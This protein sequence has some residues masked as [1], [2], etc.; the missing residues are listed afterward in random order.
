MFHYETLYAVCTDRGYKSK[1][2]ISEDLSKI[3]GKEPST[4]SSQM[5]DGWNLSLDDAARI[6]MY[7]EM[8]PKEFC[9]TFLYGLFEETPSGSYRCKPLVRQKRKENPDE[10]RQRT[11]QEII[12]FFYATHQK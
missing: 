2:E 1:K 8:T 7:F 12:D 9:D 5:K 6:A 3:L 11:R 10:N 4:I